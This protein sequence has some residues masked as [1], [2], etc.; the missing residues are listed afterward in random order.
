VDLE[1]LM[2][3]A[4][5]LVHFFAPWKEIYS[6]SP[7]VDTCVIFVHLSGILIGGGTALFTDR[8]TLRVRDGTSE[9][10][11]GAAIE[12]QESHRVVVGSLVVVLISGIALATSDLPTF[13]HAP[14]FAVKLAFVTLLVINGALLIRAERVF[15]EPSINA[16]RSDRTW[17]GVRRHA[18]ASQVLWLCTLLAGTALANIT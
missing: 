2:I 4:P 10:A 6:N 8:A 5:A 3:D 13:L 7:V 9:A 15:G 11:R 14:L 16:E 17:R 18:R 1:T 12:L